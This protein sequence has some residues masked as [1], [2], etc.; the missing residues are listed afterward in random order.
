MD[1][2]WRWNDANL[3]LLII[4][5]IPKTTQ[6]ASPRYVLF[7]PQ[8]RTCFNKQYGVAHCKSVIASLVPANN[9]TLQDPLAYVFTMDRR[10]FHNSCAD[11]LHSSYICLTLTLWNPI[12]QT[13]TVTQ[14]CKALHIYSYH[15]NHHP[16]PCITIII[17][18][19]VI[20]LYSVK[21]RGKLF[22][23]RPSLLP[24]PCTVSSICLRCLC[25]FPH[26]L[27]RTDWYSVCPQHC[28]KFHFLFLLS[29]TNLFVIRV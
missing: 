24:Y 1:I 19:I 25:S 7:Q 21:V 12:L 9:R 14:S 16:Y 2:N 4:F 13:F 27:A 5:N 6:P 8:S 23:S 11:I 26:V 15:H 10:L 20:I 22:S 28:T 17:L 3:P 18:I 29:V